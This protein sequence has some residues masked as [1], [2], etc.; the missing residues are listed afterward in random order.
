[1]ST[2]VKAHDLIAVPKW[3]G[4]IIVNNPWLVPEFFQRYAAWIRKASSTTGNDW[5]A[6]AP[7]AFSLTPGRMMRVSITSREVSLGMEALVDPDGHFGYAVMTDFRH[8]PNLGGVFLTP[9]ECALLK[10]SPKVAK[11]VDDHPYQGRSEFEP[12]VLDD[13][14]IILSSEDEDYSYSE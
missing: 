14:D 11:V 9:Q 10:G 4:H 5:D 6:F 2:L 12:V 8:T 7:Y 13:S 1:V 3:C